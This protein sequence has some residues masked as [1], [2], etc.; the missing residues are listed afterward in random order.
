[1]AGVM[2]RVVEVP[3]DE[4]AY[5]AYGEENIERRQ[6]KAIATPGQPA[7]VFGE[8]MIHGSRFRHSE[9][10][11]RLVGSQPVKADDFDGIVRFIG[12]HETDGAG[13]I[14]DETADEL[15]GGE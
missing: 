9:F 8:W 13:N 2:V 4:Y 5:T 12:A 6:S 14:E 3:A 15:C 10:V 7:S 1:P 11:V